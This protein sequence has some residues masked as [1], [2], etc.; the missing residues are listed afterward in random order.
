MKMHATRSLKGTPKFERSSNACKKVEMAQ[1]C[2]FIQFAIAYS[3]LD[4][5]HDR[6]ACLQLELPRQFDQFF[7][8]FWTGEKAKERRVLSDLVDAIQRG[9]ISL[10]RRLNMSYASAHF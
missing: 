6:A 1:F 8:N 4:S 5:S 10:L 3:Q 2:I 9:G 7:A